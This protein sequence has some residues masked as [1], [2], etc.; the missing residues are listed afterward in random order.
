MISSSQRPLPD[1]TQQS[2]Q[3]HIHAPGGIGTHNLSRRAAAD[4][5]LRPCGQWDWQH[6]WLVLSILITTGTVRFRDKYTRRKM[7]VVVLSARFVVVLHTKF[8]VVLSTKYIVVLS[9]KFVVVLSTKYIVVLHTKLVVVLSTKYIVVLSTKFVVVVHKMCFGLVY[10]LCYVLI[11]R[12]C[13]GAVNKIY[14]CLICKVCCGF[15]YRV[16]FLWS[17]TQSLLWSCL[18]SLLS[19]VQFP[20]NIFRCEK[21]FWGAFELLAETLV[22]LRVKYQ[23]LLHDHAKKMER[24]CRF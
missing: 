19:C 18:Q 11:Y 13:C 24:V 6:I 3:T 23:I 7:F 21:Y 8:V 4:L 1:N 10:K 15:V 14:C 5:R 2:Q 12:F 9:T 22:V 20:L 16:F 17:G